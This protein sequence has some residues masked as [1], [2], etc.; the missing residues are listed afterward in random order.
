MFKRIICWMT[1]HKTT[2]YG[3]GYQITTPFCLRCG[4]ENKNYSF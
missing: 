2:V 3:P 4:A 1:R